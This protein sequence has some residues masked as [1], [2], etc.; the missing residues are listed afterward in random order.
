MSRCL[1]QS[2]WQV[3]DK[4]VCVALMEFSPLQCTGKVGNKVWDKFTIKSWTCCRH[5]SWKSA[6]W[7]VSRTFMICVRDKSTTLSGTCSGLCRKVG[8]MEFGLYWCIVQG[9][10]TQPA[11]LRITWTCLLISAI[12]CQ[13]TLPGYVRQMLWVP[14]VLST[15]LPLQ[16]TERFIVFTHLAL[17]TWKVIN[18]F[19]WNFA[20]VWHGQSIRYKKFKVVVHSIDVKKRILRFLFFATFFTLFYVF[21]ILFNF[22]YFKKSVLWKSHQKLHDALLG[23]Q[24]RIIYSFI[25]L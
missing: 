9:R 15:L 11:L 2:P 14:F 13:R 5:K 17:F 19:L 12:Y 10:A 22:F 16:L 1:R 3:C 7:F 21:F 24:K 23:P 20:E 18:R 25:Y 6:T 8:V 4:P